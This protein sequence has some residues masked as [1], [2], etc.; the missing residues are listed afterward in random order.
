MDLYD[1]YY[2]A[3]ALAI[4]TAAAVLIAAVCG[5]RYSNPLAGVPM[6]IL[7]ALVAAGPAFYGTFVRGDRDGDVA[8]LVVGGLVGFVIGVVGGVVLAGGLFTF[9]TRRDQG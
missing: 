9:W 8:G 5:N 1:P 2:A 3:V 4:S 7:G 6:L